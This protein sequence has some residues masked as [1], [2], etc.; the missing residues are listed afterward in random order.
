MRDGSRCEGVASAQPKL[1]GF[2]DD[3]EREGINV[4]VILWRPAVPASSRK[5]WLDQMVRVEHLGSTSASNR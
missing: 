2:H 1:Q 3:S 5:V 4:R